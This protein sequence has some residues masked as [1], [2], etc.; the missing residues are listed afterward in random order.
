[1]NKLLVCAAAAAT[2]TSAFAQGP[3]STAFT[4][5]GELASGGQPVTGTFD[6]QFRLF[7]SPSAGAQIGATLCGENVA[8]TNGRFATVLDFGS[9][10]AGMQR[11]IEVSVRPDTGTACG[12]ASG[13]TIL[14]PRQPVTASPSSTYSLTAANATLLNGQP[15][16]FFTNASNLTTGT[17]PDARLSTNIPQLSTSSTFTGT[18]AFNGGT[19]GST[20]PFSVDSNTRVSNLN[21]DLLDGQDSTAFAPAA[22]THD[23]AAITTGTIADARLSTNI[24][25]LNSGANFL[26]GGSFAGAVGIGTSTPTSLL[27]LRNADPQLRVRNVNDPGGAMI[28][29]TFGSLQL[30]L[31]NPDV[32]AWNSIPAL[33]YRSM[34]AVDSQGRVGSTTNTSSAPAFRNLL[35]DGNGNASVNAGLTLDPDNSGNGTLASGALRFGNNSGEAIHSNRNAGTNQWGLD[36][37]TNNLPR[38][39]ITQGGNVGIGT[40]SPAA[41]LHVN[42]TIA[43]TNLP[44]IKEART[45]RDARTTSTWVGVNG[46]FATFDAVTVNVPAAG[47]LL[48]E[49]EA[50]LSLRMDTPGTQSQYV[51]VKIEETTNGSVLLLEESDSVVA[52]IGTAATTLVHP[53]ARPSIVIPTNAGTRTFRVVVTDDAA[54]ISSALVGTTAIRVT[55]FPSGL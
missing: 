23:A 27:E 42:G 20:A 21:A 29:N 34:F 25:R 31:F 49:G 38:M 16:S 18:P 46:T 24:P 3:L 10:F 19:S 32:S 52:S 50:Q 45:I 26:S 5:Q 55:Y 43:A 17:L 28:L 2:A 41:K 15:A 35:D 39:S 47:F 33:G 8:I 14:A 6:V 12:V 44:A 7:D 4:Y 9:Q 51:Y 11:F 37:F 22:H 30:G 40:Q 1:M 53:I 36:V 54:G 48:V 13:Y